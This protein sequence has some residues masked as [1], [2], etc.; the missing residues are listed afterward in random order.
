MIEKISG[1]CKARAQATFFSRFG[2]ATSDASK[3][4]DLK[5]E[6]VQAQLRFIVSA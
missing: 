6:L 5:D 1:V 3:L 4:R 2:A